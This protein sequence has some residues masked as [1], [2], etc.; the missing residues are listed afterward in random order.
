[1][2]NK[3]ENSDVLKR[4]ISDLKEKVEDIKKYLTNKVDLYDD[5]AFCQK[6]GQSFNP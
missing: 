4:N 3:V 5:S 6:I 2:V 1:M